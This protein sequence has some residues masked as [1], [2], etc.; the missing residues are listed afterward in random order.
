MHDQSWRRI[1]DERRQI[2]ETRRLSSI[3]IL[4]HEFT[5]SSESLPDS[6]CQINFS[7]SVTNSD[8][9]CCYP[10]IHIGDRQNIQHCFIRV[11][12]SQV[13]LDFHETSSRFIINK[14]H[15]FGRMDGEMPETTYAC[16]VIHKSSKVVFDDWEM[17]GDRWCTV[18]E[19]AGSMVRAMRNGPFVN[20]ASSIQWR[21]DIDNEAFWKTQ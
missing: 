3:W 10:K 1:R 5:N 2:L 20:S 11:A 7:M 14:I 16:V 19:A 17:V 21:R 6:S 4:Q 13:T 9:V 8:I 18:G 12:G 15:I